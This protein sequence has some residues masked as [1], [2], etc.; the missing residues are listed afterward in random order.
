MKNILQFILSF[1]A[2]TFILFVP[3][4]SYADKC[5][6]DCKGDSNSIECP[7][8]CGCYCS[9]GNTGKAI[10][11]CMEEN[12]KSCDVQCKN[13]SKSITCQGGG[14]GCYCDGDSPICECT[15]GGHKK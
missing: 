3:V 6:V 2:F 11:Q 14:C 9:E 12:V 5:D 13:G 10:C 8:G 1:C 4:S 7:G 15:K